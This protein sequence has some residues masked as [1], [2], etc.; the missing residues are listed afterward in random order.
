MRR[1]EPTDGPPSFVTPG[2]A[3]TEASGGRHGNPRTG[4]SSRADAL[5]PA[6]DR[7]AL[8]ALFRDASLADIVL[9]GWVSIISDYD[10]AV[11][12]LG[13]EHV[14]QRA[15]ATVI[16]ERE[17]NDAARDQGDPARRS[18]RSRA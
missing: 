8:V 6:D 9:R 2:T 15:A 4:R 7:G 11:D 3:L 12:A 14:A 18:V 17:Q 10:F 1:P 13:I 5:S 16:D